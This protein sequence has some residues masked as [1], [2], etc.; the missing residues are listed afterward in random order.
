MLRL[1][2]V[3]LKERKGGGRRTGRTGK[4]GNKLGR[5]KL[6]EGRRE[7]KGDLRL[8]RKGI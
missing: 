6:N 3:I 1:G 5:T 7:K 4:K 8:A 2:R